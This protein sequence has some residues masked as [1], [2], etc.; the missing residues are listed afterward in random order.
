MHALSRTTIYVDAGGTDD[1]RTIMRTEHVAIHTALTEFASHASIGIF[2]DSPSSLQAIRH[3]YTN[4]DVGGPR[5]Y[6]PH[7]LLLGGIADLLEDIRRKGHSTP[8]HKIRAHTN[9]RGNDLGDAA[10]KV[11]ITHF[12]SLLEHKALMVVIWET[13]ATTL[14]Q[15]S[16]TLRAC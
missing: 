12:E 3:T 1:T 13:T 8:L 11:A 16:S 14:Y 9:I 6:H 2:T 15:T 5:Y 4:P 10:A 7:S